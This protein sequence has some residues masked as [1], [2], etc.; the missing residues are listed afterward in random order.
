MGKGLSIQISHFD[1]LLLNPYMAHT[2][3]HIYTINIELDGKL[4]SY[5]FIPS[6][7]CNQKCSKIFKIK[8]SFKFDRKFK[9]YK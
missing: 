3:T 7:K 5:T 2:Y 1:M 4:L 6:L 8:S 9:E